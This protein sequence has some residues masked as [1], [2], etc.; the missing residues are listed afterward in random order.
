MS[1]NE[2][3]RP[4]PAR[5]GRLPG[6]RHRLPDDE[7]RD[8][9][10]ARLIEAIASLCAE[11][12]YANIVIADIVSRA[13]VSN[14]TF[15]GLYRGKQD[16]LFDAHKHY[17]AILLAEITAARR[18]LSQP[19]DLLRAMIRSALRFSAERPPAAE[20]LTAG[21]L[22]AGPEGRSR[23]LTTMGAIAGRLCPSAEPFSRRHL[24]ALA[25][26]I[27]AAPTITGA[28]QDEDPAASLALEHEF[29]EL[30][31]AFAEPA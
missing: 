29:L 9:Q 1:D 30:A 8:H 14:S 5:P 18:G 7:V 12:G 26:A 15:Y 4:N 31:L 2:P 13:G 11:R 23:Y 25:S 28:L 19:P 24:S 10:R 27:F 20:I 17:S 21:I 3:G 16:C 22:S 6:G